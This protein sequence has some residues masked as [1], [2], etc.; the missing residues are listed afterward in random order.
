MGKASGEDCSG[1]CSGGEVRKVVASAGGV[2]GPNLT[3][4]LLNSTEALFSYHLI[5]G[6][7][8]IIGPSGS[9]LS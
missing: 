7:I 9:T 5:A 2:G 8:A 3:Q 1:L 4:T 6:Y